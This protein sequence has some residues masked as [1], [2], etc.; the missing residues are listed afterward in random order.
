M[1]NAPTPY[2]R[3]AAAPVGECDGGAL[4]PSGRTRGAGGSGARVVRTPLPLQHRIAFLAA[5]VLAALLLG[6]WPGWP[7]DTRVPL[8][9]EISAAAPAAAGRV[10][11]AAPRRDVNWAPAPSGSCDAFFGDGFSER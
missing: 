4:S 9:V 10:A 6:V 11:A 7:A 3:V 8:A 2:M 5:L 1:R